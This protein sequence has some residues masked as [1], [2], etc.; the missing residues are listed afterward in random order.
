M[1]VSRG[2]QSLGGEWVEWGGVVWVS[3]PSPHLSKSTFH[4]IPADKVR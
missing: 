4:N 3:P 1:D 2:N